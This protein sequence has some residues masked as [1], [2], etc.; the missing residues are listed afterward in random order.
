MEE[1]ITGATPIRFLRRFVSTYLPSPFA[2]STD[3]SNA[4]PDIVTS[5]GVDSPP[6]FSDVSSPLP[7]PVCGYQL[8]ELPSPHT[9]SILPTPPCPLRVCKSVTPPSD[10][11][12]LTQPPTPSEFQSALPFPRTL[13][14]TNIDP[15]FGLEIVVPPCAQTLSSLSYEI[16]SDSE[17]PAV[18]GYN[19]VHG[20]GEV[21]ERNASNVALE[22]DASLEEITG[23]QKSPERSTTMIDNDT[24]VDDDNNY[25]DADGSED[26]STVVNELNASN[27]AFELHASLNEIMTTKK[28]PEKPTT[29][30]VENNQIYNDGDG[31][32]NASNEESVPN[33]SL[34][35]DNSKDM[36]D[37]DEENEFTGTVDRFGNLAEVELGRPSVSRTT[38]YKS[39]RKETRD[40]TGFSFNAL[41]Q[42]PD[43]RIAPKIVP[44]SERV[45]R[46]FD[47]QTMPIPK[48]RKV[49][50]IIDTN[51]PLPDLEYQ[52][53]QPYLLSARQAPLCHAVF[54]VENLHQNVAS[55]VF[56]LPK[57]KQLMTPGTQ[58]VVGFHRGQIGMYLTNQS[59]KHLH[60]EEDLNKLKS[61]LH[62]AKQQNITSKIFPTR[63]TPHSFSEEGWNFFL[64]NGVDWNDRIRDMH[65]KEVAETLLFPGGGKV[66]KVGKR[67]NRGQSLG[68]T[69][70]LCLSKKKSHTGEP[71]LVHGSMA[72]APLFVKMTTLIREMASHAGFKEPF[73]SIDG[74]F[75]KRP[76]FAQTIHADN[77]IESLSLLCLIHDYDYTTT[78]DWLKEHFDR[79]NCP[80]NNYDWL[81]CVYQDVFIPNLG[82]WATI[83]IMATYR[84]SLSD[85]LYREVRILSAAKD[86]LKRYQK[87]KYAT[88]FVVKET[89]CA[90]HLPYEE[91]DTHFEV[92]I[93]LS[94]LIFHVLRCQSLFHSKLSQELPLNLVIEMIYAFFC[95]NNPYRFHLEMVSVY[96]SIEQMGIGVLKDG[97]VLTYLSNLIRKYGS[98]D[99]IE[100]KNGVREGS[101]RFQ[102]C[103]GNMITDATIHCNLR[104]VLRIIKS[105]EGVKASFANYKRTI[106]AIEKGMHGNGVLCS[107]KVL[108][109]LAFLGIV[110]RS[111]LWYC[112]PGSRLHF[113]RLQESQFAFELADQVEQLV[114]AISLIGDKNGIIGA[115]KAE[116]LVCKLLKPFQSSCRDCVIRGVDLFW[117]TVNVSGQVTVMR[118][119]YQNGRSSPLLPLQYNSNALS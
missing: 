2:P 1:K 86:F 83:V 17:A 56:A 78:V 10:H 47:I 32:I 11:T 15:V 88:R 53:M 105:L 102:A 60:Y 26:A 36:M 119:Q 22:P 92:G 20:S 48:R 35:D 95:T 84:K 85:L 30:N 45:F 114:D 19:D 90:K 42:N 98:L 44:G 28:G 37:D 82:R 77:A 23:I 113:K 58:D 61:F 87:E 107:Q 68:W 8:V 94:P 9:L 46:S 16:G 111:F 51:Q 117:S 63:R 73:S 65:L 55:R 18:N 72:M 103:N 93:H 116:E 43:P 4:I 89:L 115:P 96:E 108:Y 5:I 79:E 64:L 38:K 80:H 12:V 3:T 76:R 50:P 31:L 112:L 81:G 69:G 29:M 75:S 66:M 67:G 57:P 100:S 118:L 54:L 6:C 104:E 7:L 25:N 70:G 109:R 99:G 24:I 97:F 110:D 62:L 39:R 27:V 33:A 14:A 74:T 40:S 21:S 59:R 34:G 101:I 49:S 106:R 13:F 91:I 52:T 71:V 41:A